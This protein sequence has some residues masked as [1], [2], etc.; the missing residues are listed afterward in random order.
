MGVHTFT[1]PE[2]TALQVTASIGFFRFRILL[3]FAGISASLSVLGSAFIIYNLFYKN[4]KR[5]HRNSFQVCETL[6]FLTSIVV[7]L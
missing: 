5:G 1:S 2:R 6:L 3:F 7:I 4:K